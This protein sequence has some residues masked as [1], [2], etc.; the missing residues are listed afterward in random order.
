M[1]QPRDVG[2]SQLLVSVLINPTY[3]V[4][5]LQNQTLW[6]TFLSNQPSSHGGGCLRFIKPTP[7]KIA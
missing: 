6:V 3:A 4:K 2:V 7:I 1:I 5:T